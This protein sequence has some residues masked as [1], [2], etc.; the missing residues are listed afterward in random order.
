MTEPQ[1]VLI[2]IDDLRKLWTAA[3]KIGTEDQWAIVAFQWMESA[4]TRIVN[5]QKLLKEHK[6]ER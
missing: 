6:L 4:N 5:L 3:R 2:T 1:A